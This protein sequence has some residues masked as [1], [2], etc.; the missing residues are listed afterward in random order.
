MSARTDPGACGRAYSVFLPSAVGTESAVTTRHR[1]LPRPCS[2]DVYLGVMGRTHALFHQ[3]ALFLAALRSLAII[4]VHP[5][6]SLPCNG[7]PD[8]CS[9]T[10]REVA[11]PSSHNSYS[12]A[13]WV[14]TPTF[15]HR[16]SR[17]FTAVPMQKNNFWN[18]SMQLAQG[19]V[20]GCR[21]G[22]NEVRFP[23]LLSYRIR[24]L[25]LDTH[26]LDNEVWLCHGPPALCAVRPCRHRNPR[27]SHLCRD[28]AH[29]AT[30]VPGLDASLLHPS[31]SSACRRKLT[32]SGATALSY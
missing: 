18:V 5:A 31:P 10:M 7:H 4:T 27:L 30:S 12:L 21:R 29:P 6:D 14:R 20:Q 9:R 24:G 13:G 3:R 28:W 22:S 15:S 17:E 26:W 1:G 2:A 19:C 16:Q 25:S 23:K 8:L 11:F 32:T